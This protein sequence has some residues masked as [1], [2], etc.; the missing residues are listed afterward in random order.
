MLVPVKVNVP[1]PSLVNPPPVLLISAEMVKSL[2]A[3]PSATV[4]VRVEPPRASF[5]LIVALVPLAFVVTL[6]FRVSVPVPVVI[7]LPVMLKAPAEAFRLFKS[8]VPAEL[9][10]VP[11]TVRSFVTNCSVP[12]AECVRL[13]KLDPPLLRVCVPLA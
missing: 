3:T 12:A 7:E 9:S 10:S 11:L 5:P 8:K 4:K 1:A 2:T 6:P 13:L